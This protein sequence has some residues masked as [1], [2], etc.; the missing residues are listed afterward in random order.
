MNGKPKVNFPNKSLFSY[1]PLFLW[2]LFSAGIPKHGTAQQ[3]TPTVVCSGGETFTTASLSLDF[4]VGEIVSESL[5]ST[6]LLLTQGFNQGPDANTGIEEKLTN[7]KDLLIYPNPAADRIYLLYNNTNTRP[8]SAEVRDIQG[9][10]IVHTCFDTNPLQI[11]LEKTAP[12]F[13]TVA[14]LF[15]NGQTI[16]KKFI[17]Q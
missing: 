3:V 16:N 13:Y 6:G 5:T 2:L 12:G 7:E 14:V 15:D 4:T 10:S 8:V 17:K 9:R 11:N 1:I